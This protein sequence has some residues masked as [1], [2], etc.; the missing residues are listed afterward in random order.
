MREYFIVE[1]DPDK[2][3]DNWLFCFGQD[4]DGKTYWITTNHVHASDCGEI[5]GGAKFDAELVVR[6]LN[7]HYQKQGA[8]A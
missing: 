6:L 3:G 7:E 2:V 1:T 4:M 5:M 8:M